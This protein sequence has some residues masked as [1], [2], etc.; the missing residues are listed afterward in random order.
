MTIDLRKIEHELTEGL[1]DKGE[2]F[3]RKGHDQK[4]CGGKEN[5]KCNGDLC[6]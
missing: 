6:V 2:R 5:A 4:P 1:V 3:R